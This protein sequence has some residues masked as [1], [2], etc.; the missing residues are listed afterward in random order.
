MSNSQLSSVIL[1]VVT[2][3]FLLLFIAT[4]AGV[5]KPLLSKTTSTSLDIPACRQCLLSRCLANGHILSQ[6]DDLHGHPNGMIN[7]RIKDLQPRTEL[8]VLP[9]PKRCE[10]VYI[11]AHGRLT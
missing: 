1:F 4:E 7:I 3:K 9:N 8:R 2:G 6:Y 10:G 11:T 5:N